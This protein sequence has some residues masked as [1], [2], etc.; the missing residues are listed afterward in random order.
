MA[1]RGY[2]RSV[3][4]LIAVVMLISSFQAFMNW[5]SLKAQPTQS[6]KQSAYDVFFA[7]EGA[8]ALALYDTQLYDEFVSTMVPS[9]M[10][11]RLEADYFSPLDTF[12]GYDDE[13]YPYEATVDLPAGSEMVSVTVGADG[14]PVGHQADFN[15]YRVPFF[16]MTHEAGFKNQRVVLGLTLPYADSNG[17]GVL[18]APD[19]NSVDIYINGTRQPFTMHDFSD[20][21]VLSKITVSFNKYT[22]ES[23]AIVEGYA[24][25]MVGLQA[26]RLIPVVGPVTGSETTIA[27]A[28]RLG[29]A[30]KVLSLALYNGQLYGGTDDSAKVYRY[31]GY[32]T[33]WTDISGPLGTNTF[34]Y[35]LA[36]YNGKLYAGTAPSGRIYQYDGAAWTDA[37]GLGSATKILSLAAYDGKLYAGT[38]DSGQVYGYDAVTG[39]TTV[40]RLGSATQVPS[41][42]LYNGQ[43]YGGT[44][45]GKVYR[46]DGGTTWTD[47]ISPLATRV[48]SLAEHN[49]GKLYAGTSGSGGRVYR[50]DGANWIDTGQL[51]LGTNTDVH[52]LALY[53]GELYG[54]ASPSGRVYRYDGPVWT[55][56]VSGPLGTNTFVHSLAVYGKKLYAGT[57]GSGRVYSIDNGLS[58]FYETG[59]KPAEKTS[60]AQLVVR[61]PSTREPATY[62]MNYALSGQEATEA[63]GAVSDLSYSEDSSFFTASNSLLSVV[64]DKSTGRY[65]LKVGPKTMFTAQPHLIEPSSVDHSTGPA[66]PL[67]V[68]S[69]PQKLSISWSMTDTKVR[70]DHLITLY[71]SRPEIFVQQRVVAREPGGIS[72]DDLEL[73]RLAADSS[74]T[75]VYAIKSTGEY[76]NPWET[77]SF[78]R[79][80]PWVSFYNP[81]ATE[82]VGIV[83]DSPDVIRT[84]PGREVMPQESPGHLRQYSVITRNAH[85]IYSNS[86]YSAR[87]LWLKKKGTAGYSYWLGWNIPGTFVETAASSFQFN[88]VKSQKYATMASLSFNVTYTDYSDETGS[89]NLACYLNDNLIINRPPYNNTVFRSEVPYRWL[90]SSG[91]NTVYCKTFLSNS[92]GIAELNVTLANMYGAGKF[93]GSN[94]TWMMPITLTG[95]SSTS[96]SA[97]VK[98]DYLKLGLLRPIDSSSFRLLNEGGYEIPMSA[99]SR[100]IYFSADV[101]AC[102]HVSRTLYLIFS[103]AMSGAFFSDA[104]S[105]SS[106]PVVSMNDFVQDN[107]ILIDAGIARPM[108]PNV[109]YTRPPSKASYAMKEMPPAVKTETAKKLVFDPAGGRAAVIKLMVWRKA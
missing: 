60:R 55:D 78:S 89:M 96:K 103:S 76:D 47:T 8:N 39:W 9:N 40:G 104:G 63:V 88:L 15:W 85:I 100:Y 52:S 24:Y 93:W 45:S 87:D 94:D 91:A 3:E 21:G 74:L 10:N 32:G 64:I 101:P 13:N 20:T 77:V 43:L 66:N 58:T 22:L 72:V 48:L 14:T 82:A 108:N 51:G 86:K 2:L 95:L 19:K 98:I 90:S 27:D 7:R 69:G 41:L 36:V 33:T 16:V 59:Q 6:I 4:A 68:A 17:D 105:P 75:N 11:Y 42:A 109:L 70:I 23:N 1:K 25:Y 46:Y 56:I 34:V 62:L 73:D 71:S 107:D 31:D 67:V 53:G 28:G 50:Y 49:D 30:T 79:Y 57:A 83:F 38:D 97:S 92:I 5:G 65:S 84:T 29:S 81:T 18:E 99:D 44:D 80:E 61:L 37:G 26:D 102:C 35:S 54:G 106:L 12:F